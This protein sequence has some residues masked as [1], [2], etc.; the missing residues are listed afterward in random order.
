MTTE[1]AFAGLA[2]HEQNNTL[3]FVLR[4]LYFV[5]FNTS[6]FFRNFASELVLAG[7]MAAGTASAEADA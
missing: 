7:I 3:Y 4:I 2:K 5:L 6:S 1:Q